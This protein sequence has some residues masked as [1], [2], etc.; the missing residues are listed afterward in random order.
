MEISLQ[1]IF[2][3]GRVGNIGMN[4]LEPVS[5]YNDVVNAGISVSHSAHPTG[6]AKCNKNNQQQIHDDSTEYRR[7]S[8]CTMSNFLYLL[9]S[10]LYVYLALWDIQNE[11]SWYLPES[12][13]STSK[14]KWFD[15]YLIVSVAA[16]SCYVIDA[17]MLFF[18]VLATRVNTNE[19]A[20]NDTTTIE[21]GHFLHRFQQTNSR[22]TTICVA[23]TFGLGATLD[24]L[25]A[26]TSEMSDSRI[27]NW[28]VVGAAHSYLVNAILILSSKTATLES[29]S[30][31]VTVL[32]DILFLIGSLVD[33][34]L[35]YFFIGEESDEVWKY[36]Y[37]GYL[38]SSVLW[39]I[40]ALLYIIADIASKD[41]C[42]TTSCTIEHSEIRVVSPV[43]PSIIFKNNNK[44][45]SVDPL[46]AEMEVE[47]QH[48]DTNFEPSVCATDEYSLNKDTLPDC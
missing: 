43:I 35:S 14:S 33:V 44:R 5:S 16:A 25:S 41:L 21:Y 29:L 12:T 28:A 37:R 19:Q 38:L 6:S 11:K 40:N 30:Q 23:I 9:G 47:Q 45:N 4:A 2:F 26:F 48:Q 1:E 3:H 31:R 22:V 42:A 39:L 13:N 46:L 27:S 10:S 8:A 34:S 7:Q 18:Y 36:V 20:S 32:G 17:L 15:P 24:L